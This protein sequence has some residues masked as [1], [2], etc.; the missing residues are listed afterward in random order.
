MS[1]EELSARLEPFRLK[2]TLDDEFDMPIG[3]YLQSAPPRDIINRMLR[4][5]KEI[6]KTQED[7]QRLIA[8]EDRLIVLQPDAWTEYRDRG[9]AWAVQGHADRAVPDLEKYLEQV[10]SAND[11]DA[12]AERLSQLRSQSS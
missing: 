10:E 11:L 7:W 12:V 1:R 4:N 2:N 6:H 3:L 5:L 9:L 8:V